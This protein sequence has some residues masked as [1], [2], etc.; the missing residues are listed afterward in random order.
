MKAKWWL[1]NGVLAVGL[2]ATGLRFARINDEP[3]M[4]PF[5]LGSG[6]AAFAISYIIVAFADKPSSDKK[7]RRRRRV[8]YGLILATVIV[9]LVTFAKSR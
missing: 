6:M 8:T 4:F 5:A 2:F 7:E 1:I 3:L 9:L